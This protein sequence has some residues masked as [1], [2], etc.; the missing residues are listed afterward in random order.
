MLNFKASVRHQLLYLFKLLRR[1]FNR[2]YQPVCSVSRYPHARPTRMDSLSDKE[3]APAQDIV[4]KLVAPRAP[5]R[6]TPFAPTAAEPMMGIAPPRVSTVITT[7][8]AMAP[9]TIRSPLC[10]LH[11]FLAA[12]LPFLSQLQAE[13][14]LPLRFIGFPKPPRPASFALP[15]L[16]LNLTLSRGNGHR[17]AP[18]PFCK[19]S[20]A[21]IENSGQVS[22]ASR[23]RGCSLF[24]LLYALPSLERVVE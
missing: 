22:C 20:S 14:S 9:P 6:A 24:M 7:H 17:F 19:P 5:V 10:S 12:E 1:F 4:P 15:Y 23:Y 16:V 8:T 18:K 11:Q 21:S 3:T 2:L 13:L